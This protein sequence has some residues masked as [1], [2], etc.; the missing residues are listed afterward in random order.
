MKKCIIVMIMLLR[1][2]LCFYKKGKGVC[3]GVVYVCV[4]VYVCG[5][6]CVCVCVCE[7]VCVKEVKG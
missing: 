1:V 3:V 5:F 6:V 2:T 7:Q 4:G